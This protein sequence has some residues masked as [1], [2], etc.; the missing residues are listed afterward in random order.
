[1]FRLEAFPVMPSH[2]HFIA[3][4]GGMATESRAHTQGSPIGKRKVDQMRPTLGQVLRAFK[5]AIARRIRLASADG[6]S[7]QRSYYERVV[8]NERELNV[9]RQYI[10]DNPS[11]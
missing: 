8:Q 7:W 11:N 10:L 6:L 9:V 5:A 3:W 4:L 1:M 2:V